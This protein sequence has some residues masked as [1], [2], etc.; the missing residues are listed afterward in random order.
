MLRRPDDAATTHRA[1]NPFA[2]LRHYLRKPNLRREMLAAAVFLAPSLLV[3]LVF[4]YVPILWAFGISF[5]N[6]QAGTSRATTFV[7]VANYVTTLSSGDFWNALRV[8]VYFV[9]LKLPLD[10]VLSLGIALLL[11]QKLRG[12]SFFRVALFMPVV[13]SMVAAA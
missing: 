4:I 1:A 8:T 11:N 7:G 12:M 2:E 5:T 9:L 13:T 10:M 3:L 6:W